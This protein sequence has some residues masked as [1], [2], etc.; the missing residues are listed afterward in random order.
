[1][2]QDKP[3]VTDTALSVDLSEATQAVKE[4]RFEDALKLFEII[5]QDHPDNIDALYLASVSSR[6]LKIFDDSI[7]YVERLLANAPD[8]GRAYQELGHIFRDQGNEDQA[9]LHLSL[10][11]I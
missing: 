8:M 5:L 9:V 4:N 6:Y 2:R 3:S 11:H 10:I 7:N 1:M